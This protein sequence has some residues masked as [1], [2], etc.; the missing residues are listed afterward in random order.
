MSEINGLYHSASDLESN[1]THVV[2]T[3]EMTGI[4]ALE[5]KYPTK[6]PMPGMLMKREYE[7]IRH[8]TVSMIGFFNVA[9][10][11]LYPAY[12]NKTRDE[13]DYMIAIEETVS[14][15]PD[16]NWI[17]IND[18]LNTHKSESLVRLVANRCEID[19]DL[20]KKGESGILKSMETRAKFLNDPSHRIRFVYT[21]KHCSWMNQIEIKFGILNRRLLRRGDYSSV[22]ELIESIKK[23]NEQSNLKARPFKWTYGGKP[24]TI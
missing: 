1:G 14:L 21:P 5:R 17:F 6:L 20:G 3:D 9:T 4:Q 16:A 7:Y 22:E 8:G 19:V 13:I 23:F 12:F 2:S 11:H 24:L 15:D 18:G 10:G